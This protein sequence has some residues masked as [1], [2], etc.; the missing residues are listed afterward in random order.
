MLIFTVLF[1]GLML[2][3]AQS[4]R[5][6]VAVSLVG[7]LAVMMVAPPPA[8]GQFCLPCV[9]QAVLDTINQVIGNWLNLINGL[10]SNIRNFYQQVVWPLNLINQAK[11]QITAMIAQFRGLL[12]SIFSINPHTATLPNPVALETIIRDRQTSDLGSVA[13][14]YVN[15]YRPVPQAGLMAPQ[16][17][18]MTDMDDAMAQDNLKTLKMAD[19]A[20][21]LMLEAADQIEN[22]AGDPSINRMAPGSAPFLTASAAT[23]NIK[24]QAVMQKM[25]AAALRQEA[26][27]VAHDNALRKRNSALA[28]QL[29][30]DM[31]NILKRQ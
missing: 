26:A 27:R 31:I 2:L 25:L 6:V 8:Q 13:Q 3:S 19:Q 20:Q 21:D 14:A 30:T 22:L 7:C 16:D 10:L 29:Q 5:R 17:R 12:Q 28:V 1:A 18:D 23:A 9:I 11:A 24:G 4:R 15:T